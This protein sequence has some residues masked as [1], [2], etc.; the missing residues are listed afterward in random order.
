[1]YA[2]FDSHQDHLVRGSTYFRASEA[3]QGI[4]LSAALVYPARRSA[5]SRTRISNAMLSSHVLRRAELNAPSKIIHPSVHN[6]VHVQVS[7]H[8]PNAPYWPACSSDC[9]ASETPGSAY[10]CPS[11]ARHYLNFP[12]VASG[13]CCSSTA[14]ADCSYQAP[15]ECPFLPFGSCS[16]TASRD[17]QGSCLD[18]HA[19]RSGCR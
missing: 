4:T 7:L 10:R 3:F 13:V 9:P 14:V 16:N 11:S 2:V 6:Y 15:W 19:T 17:S 1:M 18:S 8:H 5:C 12:V